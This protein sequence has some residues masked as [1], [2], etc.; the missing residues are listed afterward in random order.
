[1]DTVTH[2]FPGILSRGVYEIHFTLL[3]IKIPSL[4]YTDVCIN[5][6]IRPFHCCLLQGATPSAQRSSV[7]SSLREQSSFPVLGDP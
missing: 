2:P 4:V 5:T 7:E 1:M 3:P 6:S